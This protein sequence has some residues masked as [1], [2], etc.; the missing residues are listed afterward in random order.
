MGEI[1]GLKGHKP[2]PIKDDGGFEPFKTNGVAMFNYC[3]IEPDKEM[4]AFV[5]YELEIIENVNFTGRRLWK[6]SYIDNEAQMKKFANVVFAVIGKEFSTT[7]ELETLLPE[8]VASKIKV[9]AYPGKGFKKVG[10]DFEETGEKVQRHSIKGLADDKST[11]KPSSVP[12]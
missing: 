6:R 3:R 8:L 2:E 12:F 11:T 9:D 1:V 7:E 10:D 4:R 5:G